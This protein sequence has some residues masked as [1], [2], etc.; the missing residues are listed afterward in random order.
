[1][2]WTAI[3]VTV[4]TVVFVLSIPFLLTLIPIPSLEFDLSPYLKGKTAEL[5]TCKKA[6]ANVK[7]ERDRAE[8]CR[9]HAKGKLLDWP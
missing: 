2:L 8:G 1:M 6:T 5:I 3:V 4:L 9:I 7:I